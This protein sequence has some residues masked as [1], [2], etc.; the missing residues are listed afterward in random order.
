MCVIANLPQ[1]AGD[2]EWTST[3][4]CLDLYRTRERTQLTWKAGRTTKSKNPTCRWAHEHGHVLICCGNTQITPLPTAVRCMMLFSKM[5]TLKSAP[6]GEERK[7]VVGTAPSW[8]TA[9]V[10]CASQICFQSGPEPRARMQY[11]VFQ[12]QREFW[13]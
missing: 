6:F 5:V 10:C 11:V 13:G 3:L 4:D 2:R 12:L 9:V 8:H 1:Q 7:L